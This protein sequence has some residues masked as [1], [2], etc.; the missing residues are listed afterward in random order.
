MRGP[1]TSWP[2]HCARRPPSCARCA[3]H[4]RCTERR[5][6]GIGML[7]RLRELLLRVLRVPAEPQSPPGTRDALVFRASPRFYSYRLLVW[8][9]A[10]TGTL[11]GLVTGLLVL[12]SIP[13]LP[14]FWRTTEA[15]AWAGF[16]AQ[17]PVTYA[18]LRLRSDER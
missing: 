14:D 6:A 11:A 18:A 12:R 8:A 17:L 15:F 2:Q 5:T 16:L 3:T 9:L 13:G 4:W 7:D 1:M 10:Q